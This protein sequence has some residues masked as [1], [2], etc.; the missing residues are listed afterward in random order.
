MLTPRLFCTPPNRQIAESETKMFN[1]FSN[2]LGA[3]PE[4]TSTQKEVTPKNPLSAASPEFVPAAE[5]EY[6]AQSANLDVE[7]ENEMKECLDAILRDAQNT[8]DFAAAT[9]AKLTTISKKA[10]RKGLIARDRSRNNS[11]D[12]TAEDSMVNLSSP[13]SAHSDGGGAAANSSP[14]LVNSEFYSEV[15]IDDDDE[16]WADTEYASVK[17]FGTKRVQ[18]FY[19]TKE[20]RDEARRKHAEEVAQRSGRH[21]NQRNVAA[22]AHYASDR[23]NRQSRYEMRGGRHSAH[24]SSVVCGQ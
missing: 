2:F 7:V 20:H 19:R 17:S 18:G 10:Q 8:M 22:K 9:K 3:S 1:M 12:S 21:P 11:E 6:E 24:A 23:E 4:E 5:E 15:V 16:C 13:G 14:S